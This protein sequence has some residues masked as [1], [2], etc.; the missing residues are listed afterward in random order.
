MNHVIYAE[1]ETEPVTSAEVVAHSR[2]DD[3]AATAE[4]TLI[5]S[6]IKTVRTYVEQFVGPIMPQLWYGYL[7]EWPGDDVITIGKPRVTAISRMT[8][9][10]ED[11]TEYVLSADSYRLDL[12]D[13]YA[14]I[15]LRENEDWPTT[16]LR[17][18]NAIKILYRAGWANAAAVPA[19][20][21]TAI[22]VGVT[23]LYENRIMDNGFEKAIAPF[24]VNYRDWGF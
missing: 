4:A 14:R 13:T 17:N 12:T 8:Y 1:P 3:D 9:Y 21:K 11:D 23:Y 10:D 5:T 18:T 2:I 6:Y 24:V 19:D 15:V 16:T 20:L 7:D 22:I